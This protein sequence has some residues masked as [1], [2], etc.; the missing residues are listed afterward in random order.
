M[1][2]GMSNSM[3]QNGYWINDLKK[4]YYANIF[5]TILLLYCYDNVGVLVLMRF[6][7]KV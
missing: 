6:M 5:I 2:V 1:Y 3:Y 7:V 4:T